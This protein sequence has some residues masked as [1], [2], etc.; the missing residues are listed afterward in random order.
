MGVLRNIFASYY[1]HGAVV[2]TIERDGIREERLVAYLMGA[3]LMT[4]AARVPLLVDQHAALTGDVPEFTTFAGS[5]FV[6]SLIFAPLFMYLL[7]AI[8]H[9]AFRGFWKNSSWARARLALFWALFALQPLVLFRGLVLYKVG[10]EDLLA[11]TAYATGA[12][13]LY[14]WIGGMRRLSR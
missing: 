7:A 5:N 9:L 14:V 2:A 6:A 3:S 12:L 11:L 13:F 8:S 10:G 1:S 4:F